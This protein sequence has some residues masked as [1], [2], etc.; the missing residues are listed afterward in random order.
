MTSYEKPLDN[1][2]PGNGSVCRSLKCMRLG[3]NTR[4]PR[5]SS[6]HFGDDNNGSDSGGGVSLYYNDGGF[7]GQNLTTLINAHKVNNFSYS[8]SSWCSIGEETNAIAWTYEYSN[9]LSNGTGVH[10][11]MFAHTYY[12]AAGNIDAEMEDVT[13]RAVVWTTGKENATYL[14]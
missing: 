1:Y 4:Q 8:C 14:K 9:K 7:C 6:R 12:S 11:R 13:A 2:L 5:T 10:P 3:S